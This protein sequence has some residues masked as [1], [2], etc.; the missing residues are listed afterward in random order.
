M[1]EDFKFYVTIAQWLVMCAVGVYTWY[2]NRQTAA[3]ADLNKVIARVT[4][5]ESEIKHLPDQ[6]LVN[7]LAGDMKAVKAELT[8]I[9]ESISPL[10]R[11]IE[12]LNGYLLNNKK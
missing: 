8:A 3:A 11:N 1:S 7:G 10:T 5:L 4:T 9:K 2:A 6:A 12:L